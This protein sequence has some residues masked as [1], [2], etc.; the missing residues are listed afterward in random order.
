[1]PESGNSVHILASTTRSADRLQPSLR[2]YWADFVL[3]LSSPTPYA[4]QISEGHEADGRVKSLLVESSMYGL[5]R[6][7]PFIEDTPTEGV[8]AGLLSVFCVLGV[9]SA[10]TRFFASGF[11][12]ARL[13]V[14]PFQ[15]ISGKGIDHQSAVHSAIDGMLESFGREAL[16]GPGPGQSRSASSLAMRSV[17]VRREMLC[18][19]GAKHTDLL[20]RTFCWFA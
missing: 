9:G 19:N 17:A 5:L 6:S 4:F 13:S 16:R 15:L 1:M 2:K 11:A 8:L 7:I 12:R 14:S 10:R 18:S 20:H 3:A